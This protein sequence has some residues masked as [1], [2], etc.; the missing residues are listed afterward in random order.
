MKNNKGIT[1]PALIIA[2]IIMIILAGVTLGGL[3]GF[4][5]IG[6]TEETRWK[7][8]MRDIAKEV[9]EYKFG[10]KIE[11]EDTKYYAGNLFKNIIE[12][13]E[14]EIDPDT[15]YNISNITKTANDEEK[16]YIIV[17][18]GELHY[19]S[20]KKISENDNYVK[21]AQEIGIK[22]WDYTQNEG[23]K[24]INGKYEYVN[25]LWLCTP[26]LN[27]GLTKDNTR[28]LNL[29]E[30]GN[31][32]PGNWINKKPDDNWYDYKNNVW[33]NLYIEA[34]GVE[35]YY[36]WIP[37]Y[38]YKLDSKNQR[39]DVIFVDIDN[40]CKDEKGETIP[41]EELQ[42]QGYKIPEA[43]TF[44]GKELPGYWMSKYQLSDLNG[45]TVDYSTAATMTSITIQDIKIN[46]TEAVAKYTYSV[47]G[48]ILHESTKPENFTIKNLAR[49]NRSI[50]VTALDANG[51]II[52]SMTRMYEVA[53][54]N[55]PDVSSFDPDTT[56]YVWWDDNG[57]EHNE[58]PIS[59][60]PPSEWYDYTFAYW[61]NIVTRNDGLETYFV[62]IPRYSYYVDSQSQ[63]SYVKFLKG[64]T[65]ETDTGYKIPEAFTFG[66]KE[67]TGYWMTK[68]Q[69]NTEEAN[70]LINAEMSAG[71]NLIRIQDITGTLIDTAITNS[72]PVKYEYY[73]NGD[74][75]H[76]GTDNKEHYV[77][78]G[79]SSNT[80]Y[81]INIIA[82]N[83][84][85]DEFIG[86]VTKKITTNDANEPDVSS[87][88][89]DTTYY[90]VYDGDTER[91][92][93]I[94]Q[95]APSDW[96]DYSNQKWANIVTTANNTETYF[97]WIPR[98]EY[99]ILADRGA[100]STADRRIDVT[101]ITTDITN[102]NCSNN[103]KVPEAF[104]FAGKELPGYWITK[105]QLNN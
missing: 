87:F 58:I 61:A 48:T 67:L 69:L 73:L 42:S 85:T 25:G 10:L 65:R 89:K 37:R 96:Y 90:V 74:K 81:T 32:V 16:E 56:F 59:K 15:V 24:V 57:I 50:N 19:V 86:A 91:R 78:E 70:K 80:Q 88:D 93:S 36:V 6:R 21:W 18:E 71:S 72:T 47:N 5:L 20:Q 12:V 1:L 14:L 75:K 97:V 54:V 51:E 33:A 22:I 27:V 95:K 105:Y 34:H 31:L 9:D 102:S 35:S 83:E 28:Y 49:G 100:L 45:Y 63:R 30:N 52:G 41:W 55:E 104:T 101:F 40:S 38:V 7:S 77:F 29:D 46:T 17:Y 44:A 23:I 94:K 11:G 76:E 26:K 98:Y 39:S 3:A 79:L 84:T 66:G 82:R 13:E 103:Y 53:E 2:I 4:G 92:V 60:D 8:R 62:W 43:F 64:T 68:Y 99:K